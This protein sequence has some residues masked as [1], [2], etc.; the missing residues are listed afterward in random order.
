MQHFKLKSSFGIGEKTVFAKP[1]IAVDKTY[2]LNM[3]LSD[4]V[5]KNL[6]LYPKT[7]Y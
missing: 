6:L 5:L 4:I 7:G 2:F 3:I 1:K